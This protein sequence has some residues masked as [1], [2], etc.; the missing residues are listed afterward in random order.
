MSDVT[1]LV[2]AIGAVITALAAFL[3]AR[4]ESAL[5]QHERDELKA[6]LAKSNQRIAESD[7]RI[8]ELE[9]VRI[10]DRRDIILIGE[11]LAQARSDNAIMA[12][13]FNQI[14]TEFYNVTGHKPSANLEALKRLQT[15]Q[16]ITGKLGPLD[17]PR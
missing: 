11:S 7:K 9:T 15:I 6:E 4:N 13:A 17:A 1:A 3:K 10:T 16:Y 14:W 8:N 5:S 12:E 2:L